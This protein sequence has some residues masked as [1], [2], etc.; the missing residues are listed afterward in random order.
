MQNSINLE[1]M[2]NLTVLYVED[3][4]DIRNNLQSCFSSMF[5]K[6]ITAKDGK[7]GFN[8]FMKHQNEIDVIITDLNMPHIDGINM[9]KK[10]KSINHKIACIITTAYSDKQYLIDSI[11][12][13][14][15]HY[16]LKPFKIESLLREVE[17]SYLSIHYV[18]KLKEQ[19]EQ[20]ENLARVFNSTKEE[21]KKENNKELN[22]KLTIFSEIMQLLDRR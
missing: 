5:K 7:E 20:I 10:I 18:N 17:K 21:L 22:I 1:L 19:N 2:K 6:C 12:Y 9:I 16:I 14:V 3:E 8:K 15:N 11:N 4:Q 13:G